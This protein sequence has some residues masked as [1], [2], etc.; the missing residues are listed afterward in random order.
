MGKP[1]LKPMVAV[2]I[3]EYDFQTHLVSRLVKD[4]EKIDKI[5]EFVKQL[6]GINQIVVV[7]DVV[8]SKTIISLKI[9]YKKEIS[10]E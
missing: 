10:N 4:Q 9:D 7:E 1:I 8:E 5:V 2:S 3:G 6:G